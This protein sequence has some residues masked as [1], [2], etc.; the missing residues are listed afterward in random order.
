MDAQQAYVGDL[1]M[2]YGDRLAEADDVQ[3][4]LSYS[5]Q[6]S[7]QKL[8]EDI[9]T[10]GTAGKVDGLVAV[11]GGVQI[12][13]PPDMEDYYWTKHFDLYDNQGVKQDEISLD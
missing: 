3:V 2:P 13:T 11:L 4:E 9:V 12:N 10:S 6:D 7:Q 5:L 1:L 8:I